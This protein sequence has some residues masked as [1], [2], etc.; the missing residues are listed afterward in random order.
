MRY[1]I[2]HPINGELN[3][4]CDLASY[5]YEAV[6]EVEANSLRDAFYRSQNDFN[7]EYAL[8]G[9]RSTSVGD[10]IKHGNTFYMVNGIGFSEI[11]KNLMRYNDKLNFKTNNDEKS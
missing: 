3:T 1:K 5:Q 11:A 8:A 6:A 2:F 7:D 9:L 4:Q 10:V